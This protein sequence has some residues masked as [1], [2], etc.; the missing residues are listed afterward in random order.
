MTSPQEH[1]TS[2]TKALIGVV[3]V[4]LA[5]ALIGGGIAL[6]NQFLRTLS[7]DV[8]ECVAGDLND[9]ALMLTTVD[10]ASDDAIAK[11]IG[12]VENVTVDD[13]MRR[14]QDMCA[15]FEGTEYI[16]FEQFGNQPT[17]TIMC[18]ELIEF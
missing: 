15:S 9:P 5:I 4:V 10:C 3:V 8:G 14:G 12:K 18:F 17:G 16:Y 7:A 1:R 13:H 2:R 11:V 6:Y